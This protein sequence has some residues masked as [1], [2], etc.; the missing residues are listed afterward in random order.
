TTKTDREYVS[1]VVATNGRQP[2]PGPDGT[3]PDPPTTW[4]RVYAFSPTQV[5]YLTN[6]TKGSLVYVE[7]EYELREPTPDAEPGSVESQR[8]VF[9]R[10]EN[11]KLLKR[12]KRDDDQ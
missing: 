1:Y 3:R 6:L 12:S 10:Q 8:Q 5:P 7:A 9:L 4:H 2:P 11:I